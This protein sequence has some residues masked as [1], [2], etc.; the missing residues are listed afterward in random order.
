VVLQPD[1][2][3]AALQ[4]LPQGDVMRM[5]EED[6]RLADAGGNGGARSRGEWEKGEGARPRGQ[7]KGVSE[8]TPSALSF[9]SDNIR[10][11]MRYMLRH[12]PAL[13]A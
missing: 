6:Q 4:W 9:C 12:L 5:L 11:L 2:E 10:T 8:Q 13:A 3:V 7:R 1:S